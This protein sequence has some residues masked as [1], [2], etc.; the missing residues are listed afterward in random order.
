MKFTSFSRKPKCDARIS[1][2]AE[3]RG[4]FIVEKNASRDNLRQP[5]LQHI[6]L[7]FDFNYYYFSVG[8]KID[9]VT[10]II[11]E[12]IQN[13]WKILNL[14]YSITMLISF[15]LL[16]INSKIIMQSSIDSV[17][18]IKLNIK[19]ISMVKKS[20]NGTFA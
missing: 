14:R 18:G 9:L 17:N 13:V 5:D 16:D 15:S 6:F 4:R 7:I 8:Q 19:T 1:K 20:L 3:K 2:R 10:F 11:S 12:N